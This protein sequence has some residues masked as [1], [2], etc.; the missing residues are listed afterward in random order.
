MD[1]LLQVVYLAV[2]IYVAALVYFCTQ[3]IF[4]WRKERTRIGNAVSVFR[5][6]A[7]VTL[8]TTIYLY[9]FTRGHGY[10]ASLMGGSSGGTYSSASIRAWTPENSDLTASSPEFA[11][12]ETTFLSKITK[13]VAMCV[14]ILLATYRVL[15]RL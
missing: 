2:V 12:I 3:H 1:I 4:M 9:Y 10:P 11:T 14:L 6:L 13:L 15:R 8:A 5:L 7:L